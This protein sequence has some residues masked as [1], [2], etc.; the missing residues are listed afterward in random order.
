MQKLVRYLSTLRDWEDPDSGMWEENQEVHASSVGAC[1]A[2]LMEIKGV[3]GIDV[4]Q[5]IIEQGSAALRKLMPRESGSKFADLALLSLIWPYQVLTED[6]SLEVL[7][8]VE[9][10]L[11]RD[12]GV[13]RYKHDRYYNKTADGYSEEAEWTFGLSWLAI[14][15]QARG[16]S[17]KARE[18]IDQAKAAVCEAGVPELYYSNSPTYNDNTPL[19]WSESMF[20]VAL[21][22]VAGG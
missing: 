6:E 1:V 20:I 2:G 10:H 14:I 7:K 3:Q 4:P 8:N 18:Y 16:D 5:E 13:I 19:G 12:R 21:T 17:A 11:L 22:M 15:Y 9:Y